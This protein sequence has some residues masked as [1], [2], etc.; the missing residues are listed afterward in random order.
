MKE[1]AQLLKKGENLDSLFYRIR[2]QNTIDEI[3]TDLI[4]ENF[5]EF[6]A[7]DYFI[8]NDRLY[9]IK[10]Q[11]YAWFAE[12]PLLIKNVIN[13]SQVLENLFLK[14][15]GKDWNIIDTLLMI[16]SSNFYG[17]SLPFLED[18]L[19]D[20][21]PTEYV[22][23]VAFAI[24]ALQKNSGFHENHITYWKKLI[25]ETGK[26][27]LNVVLLYIYSKYSIT[28]AIQLIAEI[29]AK[30]VE[31]PESNVRLIFQ[32]LFRDIIITYIDYYNTFKKAE[33]IEN[34]I[35]WSLDVASPWIRK[36]IYDAMRLSKVKK[37][38]ELTNQ[39][40]SSFTKMLLNGGSS[41][42]PSV[43]FDEL[44]NMYDQTFRGMNKT[45]KGVFN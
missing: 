36:L 33:R 45:L 30:G 2:N 21:L 34:L 3:I 31:M 44:V 20:D 4:H 16:T 40:D 17:L 26:F 41:K 7:Y 6:I 10:E 43:G 42:V 24:V 5:E 13:N 35:K 39:V 32:N 18:R 11:M 38:L 29:D 22:L 23:K 12:S 25:E 14:H 9:S 27:D 19:K 37:I 1:Y 28:D 8:L 15:A